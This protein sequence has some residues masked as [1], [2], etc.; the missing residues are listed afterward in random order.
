MN[1]YI[2]GIAAISMLIV[3]CEGKRS[4][5]DATV[6][7]EQELA[8]ANGSVM[9]IDT[10][11]S[12][13]GFTGWGVGKNHPGKFKFNS[14]S[15]TVK[16]G[17]VTSGTFVIRIK[18]LAMDQQEEVY[19]TKLRGHLLNADFFDSE[20]YPEA[21]FE[22]TKVEPYVKSVT[23]SSVV[24]GA[25]KRIHGNLTLKGITKNVSF[26]AKVEVTEDRVTTKAN[27][28]ID[29][30]EWNMNYNADKESMK[31]KFISHDVNIVLDITAK[32]N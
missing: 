25:N 31:D 11:G 27:F 15:V 30:T 7:D 6:T 22:I 32:M 12:V 26:P 3:A 17:E 19:Q 8:E 13:I 1:K 20:V 16:D 24:A 4:G 9:M 18:S 14:G 21:K 10:T 2:L 28:D 5:D 23:D 29:R